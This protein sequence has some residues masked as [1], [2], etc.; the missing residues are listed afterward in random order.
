MRGELDSLTRQLS[1]RQV[2]VLAYIAAGQT[3]AQIA[4][5]MFIGE[6]T[7]KQHVQDIRSKL[8]ASNRAHA[9]HL[10]HRKGILK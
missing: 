8:D 4:S 6:S 10:A 1:G 2:E 5:A 9:V 3:D 7:V